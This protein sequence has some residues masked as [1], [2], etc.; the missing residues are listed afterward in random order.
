MT[1]RG[2]EKALSF[3]HRKGEEARPQP[4]P[5]LAS[6]KVVGDLAR[7][8]VEL[9]AE[10]APAERAGIRDSLAWAL[11]ANGRFDEAVAEEEQALE[12]AA[13]DKKEEFQG[14]VERLKQKIEAEIDPAQDEER[15]ANRRTE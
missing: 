15:G 12:E 1:P 7:R 11:F 2:A 5:G 9:A 14:Y 10:L 8:A 13:S 4:A 6:G 3:F